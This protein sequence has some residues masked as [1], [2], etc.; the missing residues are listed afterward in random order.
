MDNILSVLISFDYPTR[1][2]VRRVQVRQEKLFKLGL[3]FSHARVSGARILVSECMPLSVDD[4]IVPWE[5]FPTP[6]AIATADLV[7]K[8]AGTS[9]CCET[10]E[11]VIFLEVFCEGVRGTMAAMK[12]NLGRRVVLFSGMLTVSV[13][14]GQIVTANP[15]T[16][17]CRLAAEWGL[18]LL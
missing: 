9:N 3:L 7:V 16:V 1:K 10:D 12:R 5:Q 4:I 6:F 15:L 18:W 14:I 11:I 17:N 2:V 13:T 8:K